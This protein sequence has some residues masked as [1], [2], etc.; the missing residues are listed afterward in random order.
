MSTTEQVRAAVYVRQSEDVEEGIK[1]GLAL[2]N[3][4]AERRG[5]SVVEEYKDNA[6]SASKSRARSDWARM[7][8]DARAG[9]FTVVIGVDMDRLL[10]SVQDLLELIDTGVKVCLT[11]GEIDLTTADGEFRATLLA[12]LA[13]FEVRRKSERTVRANKD[14]T[15][16][17][18]PVAGKRRFGF[19]GADPKNGRKVNTVQHPEEAEAVRM[20]FREYLDGASIRSLAARAGWRTLRVR[21]TLSNPAYAGWV[22]HRGERFDAHETVDRIVTREEFS[23]VQGRLSE[24]ARRTGRGGVIRHVASGVA[25]CGVCGGTLTYRNAYLCLSDLSHPTIKAEYLESRIR[26]EVVG[27]LMLPGVVIESDLPARELGAVERRLAALDAKR[28]DVL[29]GLNDESLGLTMKDLRPELSRI[30]TE[31][32]ALTVRRGEVLT[33]SAAASMLSGLKRSIVD[34]STHRA[35]VDSAADV[36]TILGERFDALDMDRKRELIRGLI[37]IRVFPGRSP[38]RVRVWHLTDA[39]QVLN[40][41]EDAA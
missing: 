2:C 5:W 15:M 3:I 18:F 22:V 33:L 4:L 20:L 9:L 29:A 24:T 34:S 30:A 40:A 21:E 1:R 19:L 35:S 8:K 32:A 16:N 37:K 17:G 31:A 6:V 14:R 38:D 25:R 36:A 28:A 13:R 23:Q 7:L 10:R 12:S 39:G 26:R 11:D 27:A 41:D